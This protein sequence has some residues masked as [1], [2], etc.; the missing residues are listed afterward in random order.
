MNVLLVYPEF[1]DTFWSFKFALKFIRKKAA[2]PPL[3]LLTVAALLPAEWPKKLVDLN[4]HPLAEMDLKWAD[5]A[6][7]S[8]MTV[9]R[10]SAE[11]TIDRFRSAGVRIVA[12]GPLFTIEPHLYENV[13][14]LVLNEAELTLP[15]FLEDL[16]RGHPQHLYISDEFADIRQSPI[17]AWELVD[18]NQYATMCVQY[19][20]G[21]PYNCDFCNVTA[22]FGHRPRIKSAA[23]VIAELEKIYHLGWRGSVFFVDDNLIGDKKHLRYELL[24]ALKEWRKDKAGFTFSTQVSINLADD[25]ELMEQ[26]VEAGFTSVFIGIES[27]NEESLAECNKKQNLHRNLIEDVRRI[28]RAGMQVQ[29]GFIVGFDHDSP[30]VFSKLGEFIQ[31]SGIVTAM[32]GL[33]QAPQGTK[34]YE[35]LRQAGRLIDQMSGDNVDGTTNILPLMDIEV[36]RNGYKNLM[37]SLYSPHNYYQRILT[38]LKEYQPPKIRVS[39][40]LR[41]INQYLVAF[42]QSVI[43]LGILGKERVHYWKLFFWTLF[44]KPRSPPI[45]ITLAIYGYHFRKIC[46]LRLQTAS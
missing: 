40:N 4:V 32:V 6:F 11:Q 21:C 26:M 30:T 12:G 9:Q 16:R 46:E 15:I 17:P 28:Y 38:F 44:H 3:G 13:D 20:R 41:F 31:N 42:F 43:R 14:H 27:S 2:N 35:K 7:L 19:S 1:P 36:L 34:L 10:R 5:L 24:P 25:E 37:N 33:L 18:M 45:A 8:A 22:L 29:G 23:Q 39:F